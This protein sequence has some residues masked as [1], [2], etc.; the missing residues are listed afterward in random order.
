[1]G[2]ALKELAKGR[3]DIFNLA[4][5]D[6]HVKEGWNARSTDDPDNEAHVA[7]LA[8]SI[9]EVGVM[10]PLTVFREDGKIYVSDGH[11][12]LAATLRAIAAGAPITAVPVKTEGRGASEVDF[13]FSQISR[14]SGKPLSPFE[15]GHVYKRL[16]AFG[17]P[18][19]DIA[20]KSGKSESH[21]SSCLDLQGASPAIRNLVSTGKVSP[22]LAMKVMRGKGE[23]AEDVLNN[24]VDAATQ[25]G[26]ARA[27]EQHIGQGPRGGKKHAMTR[28]R[29]LFEGDTDVDTTG[30]RTIITMTDANWGEVARILDI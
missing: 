11:C 13:V 10:E 15:Q 18:V 12:R 3:S 9:A 5:R 14:N 28:L 21:I 29:E 1:M 24:A 2:T 23:Q 26:K 4:P 17:W 7:A 19:G 27:T 30:A 8:L 25:Q 6:I 20:K 22:S 16:L